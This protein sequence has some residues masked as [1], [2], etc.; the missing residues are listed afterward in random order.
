MRVQ[1]GG[2]EAYIGSFPSGIQETLSLLRAAIHRAAQ[3]AEGAIRYGIPAYR[4]N[5]TDLVHFAAFK[6]HLSFF[7]PS[8]SVEQLREEELSFP[9][10]GTIRI[11]LVMPVPYELLDRITRF[12]VTGVRHRADRG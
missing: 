11:P 1:S 5:G 2:I 9:G 12:R 7:P 10:K 4:R 6:D 8:G 3:E